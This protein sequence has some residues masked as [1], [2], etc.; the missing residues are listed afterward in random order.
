MTVETLL[1]VLNMLNELAL[2]M[3]LWPL[4]YDDIDRIY[5]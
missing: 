4:H 2:P 3:F 5:M 1:Q